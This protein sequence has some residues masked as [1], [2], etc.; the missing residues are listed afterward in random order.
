MT[1]KVKPNVY[2]VDDDGDCYICGGSG[3][4]GTTKCWDGDGYECEEPDFCGC[5][6]EGVVFLWHNPHGWVLKK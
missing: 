4:V 5:T 1:D 2:P 3:I 6:D